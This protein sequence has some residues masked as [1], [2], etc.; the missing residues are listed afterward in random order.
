MEK[1]KDCWKIREKDGGRN[2]SD[3]SKNL[4]NTWNGKKDSPKDGEN[5]EENWEKDTSKDLEENAEKLEEKSDGWE[6]SIK[7]YNFILL[8][9]L[10]SNTVYYSSYLHDLIL[11]SKTL[12][13][14]ECKQGR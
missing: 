11:Y 5:G 10:I 8:I 7:Y 12:Y 6:V 2:T 9:I 14:R 3:Y 1:E 4:N 13:I